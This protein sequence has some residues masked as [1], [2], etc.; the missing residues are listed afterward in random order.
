MIA[1]LIGLIAGACSPTQASV[2]SRIRS[3]LHSTYTTSILNFVAAAALLAALIAVIERNMHIPLGLIAAKPFWIWLGGACGTAIVMLNIICLPKL[4]SAKNA[5]LI[6]FGQIMT[7]LVIDHFGLFD[8]AQISMNLVRLAGAVLVI[9]GIALV[10]GVLRTGRTAEDASEVSVETSGKGGSQLVYI[11]L[12]M[13]C[14][15][16]CSAQV[17]INGA[18]KSVT[19]SALK[20]T[21]IS[22]VVGLIATLLIT[23]IIIIRK[24][25]AGI[26][27]SGTPAKGIKFRIWMLC[28]GSLAIIIVGGNAIAA[29]VLGTGIVTI[30]NLIGMMAAGLVIDA[31]GFLGIEKKPVTPAK[32]AGMLLMTAGAALI[33]LL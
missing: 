12:A 25:V 11:I 13:L 8:S 20:A 16:A 6:C 1:F 28:G 24:G 22:M 29:P 14:G 23:A 4:G 30:L 19:D 26:Y 10:N 5:M 9:V 31:T 2:N 33:S 32:V 18:L 3:E 7:G 21:F 15:F 17:A 27:D